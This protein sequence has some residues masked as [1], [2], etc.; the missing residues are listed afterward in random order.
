MT[1]TKIGKTAT[2]MT[3]VEIMDR[4]A[5]GTLTLKQAAQ[6]LDLSYRQAKRL[7]QRY[8]REGSAGLVHGHTGHRSNRAKP[9]ELREQALEFVRRSGVWGFGPTLAAAE[10]ASQK[11]LQVSKETLR[12]WMLEAGLWSGSRNHEPQPESAP[13]AHFGEL[14]ILR[15]RI[16]AWPEERRSVNWIMQL[17]DA[18]T[19]TIALRVTREPIW[20]LAGVLRAWIEQYGIPQALQ[21][22]WNRIGIREPPAGT[23]L[24]GPSPVAQ[25]R[26]MCA[27]LNIPIVPTSWSDRKS[28][29]LQA[30]WERLVDDFSV[31]A[32]RNDRDANAY[33]EGEYVPDH[34]RLFARPP[35]A[36]ADFHRSIPVGC[37]LNDVFRS[38]EERPIGHDWIVQ[39]RGRLYQVERE[40]RYAPA[41]DKVIV[42]EWPGRRLEIHYRGRPI[43]WQQLPGTPEGA[44][45]QWTGP[46]APMTGTFLSSATR[47][48]S[49][50]R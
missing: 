3:R 17:I 48:I 46:S 1:S 39:Y 15:G 12:R 42:F 20:A 41:R 32:I 37:A 11:G 22:D 6:L 10:L 29:P 36:S 45:G 7:S 47:D 23:F 18:A 49:N 25:F 9:V 35:E 21:I 5:S 14:V 33:L 28:P 13:R 8:Q 2:N 40:S 30:H 38:E 44:Q 31:R 50:E 27:A 19:E 43:K 16:C 26:R 34:N 4:V 24:A